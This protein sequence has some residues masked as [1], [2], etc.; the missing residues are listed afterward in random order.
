MEEQ[1][2]ELAVS[3]L[4]NYQ[5]NVIVLGTEWCLYC[6]KTRDYLNLNMIS[7]FWID[8]EKNGEN[9]KIYES[10]GGTGVPLV[11]TKESIIE[12]Y[13]VNE[14]KKIDN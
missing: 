14:L 3:L 1:R 8:I 5:T 11:I 2:L 12:G 6:K 13:K 7:Y 10:F 4:E 9:R